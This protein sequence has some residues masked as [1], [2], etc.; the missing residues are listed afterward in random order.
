[1]LYQ[2]RPS[3]ALPDRAMIAVWRHRDW[4]S[5]SGL[6]T[7]QVDGVPSSGDGV[8]GICVEGHAKCCID[9]KQYGSEADRRQVGAFEQGLRSYSGPQSSS[10]ECALLFRYGHT[11]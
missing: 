4:P 8:A 7:E 1:M 5:Y 11:R 6:R 3:D 10:I 9:T 2:A